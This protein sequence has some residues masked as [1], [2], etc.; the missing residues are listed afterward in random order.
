MTE[1][2][3]SITAPVTDHE[4]NE[5]HAVAFG[6]NVAE[7]PWSERLERH[8]L[9]WV[10]ARWRRSLV[11]FL[12]VIGD[13]GAHAVL[14]DTCVHPET[15]GQGIGRALVRSATDEAERRGCRWLHADYEPGLVEFYEGACG[16]QRTKAGLLRMGTRDRS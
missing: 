3:L 13:G 7:V 1:P 5:L 14:L 2:E 15:R 12:N 16:M 10:T 6:H 8:S 11:G 4:V 9:F